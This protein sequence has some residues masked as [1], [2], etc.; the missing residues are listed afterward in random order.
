MKRVFA[1]IGG[2]RAGQST[3]ATEL[4]LEWVKRGA[5]AC[6]LTTREQVESTGFDCFSL[7]VLAP[8]RTGKQRD[9]ARLAADL[10]QLKDYDYILLDL[11]RGSV[12][13]A[14]A[15]ALSGAEL[16]MTLNFEQGALGGEIGAMFR[17][18]ARRPPQRPVQLVL[19]KV[20]N[21]EAASDAAERLMANLSKKLNLSARLAA[22]LPWDPDL[23]ALEEASPL[24]SVILPTAALVRAVPSLADALNGDAAQ[25][26]PA[27]VAM[28]FWEQFQTL[29][30]QFQK[31]TDAP[32]E[33]SDPV[34][35]VADLPASSDEPPR[36]PQ[37]KQAPVPAATPALTAELAR[38]VAHLEAL[39]DEVR[40][41]RLE[42]ARKFESENGVDERRRRAG[43][44]EPI[45]LD[46]E[47]FR[48]S[49]RRGEA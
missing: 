28:V 40:R 49:H 18:M 41:L 24:V 3:L 11:P 5:S 47:A 27:P 7:P 12:D 35:A 13:I 34:Y 37:A 23:A 6:V 44:G 29:L 21:S 20:R 10:T 8:P 30:Q 38:I 25:D 36:A 42:L 33:L 1:L 2:R 32:L 19:N 48:R 26:E 45:R 39:T 15:A 46:F 16:I 4:A 9:L 14:V 17:E 31:E 22:S 43:G